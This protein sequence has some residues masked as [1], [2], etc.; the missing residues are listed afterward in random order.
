MEECDKSRDAFDI[1][2]EDSICLVEP[3]LRP[4]PKKIVDFHCDDR[5]FHDLGRRRQS[6]QRSNAA[7]VSKYGVRPPPWWS[8]RVGL[9]GYERYERSPRGLHKQ[10]PRHLP[11][12]VSCL[13]DATV[14][15]ATTSV[16]IPES[17]LREGLLTGDVFV[18]RSV[19][20]V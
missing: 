19:H 15:R 14:L 11:W 17:L 7:E 1:Q 8:Y 3:K 9:R 13:F 10:L 16:L 12:I 20:G 5:P 6:G 2:F 18:A 4:S